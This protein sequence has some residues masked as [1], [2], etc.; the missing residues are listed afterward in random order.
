ML[1]MFKDILSLLEAEDKKTLKVYVLLSLIAPVID[2]VSVSAIIPILN[3]MAAGDVSGKM[4]ATII[5]I[6]CLILVKGVF[7]LFR[8]LVANKFTNYSANRLALKVFAGHNGE[9]LLKHNDRNAAQMITAVRSDSTACVTMIVN[10]IS[11]IVEGITWGCLC[12]IL[13]YSAGFIGLI[14]SIVLFVFMLVMYIANRVKMRKYG[15]KKRNLEIRMNAVITTAYG[16]YKEL[17]INTKSKNMLKRYADVSTE[18]AVMQRHYAFYAAL[19]DVAMK[20]SLQAAIY[21]IL[22]IAICLKVDFTIYIVQIITFVTIL[23]KLIPET[24]LI[25]NNLNTI[26]YN[27]K[28][29]RMLSENIE[30]FRKI[31]AEEEE[32]R[33]RR[34]HKVTINKGLKVE[35][36][37]FGYTNSRN[38]FEDASVE[39]PA[40][41]TIAIVGNSGIGKTSFLDLILGLLRPQDG[42]IYYDDYDIVDEC[43]SEGKC[44]GDLGEIVSYIPQVVFMNGDTVK[45]NVLFMTD[46][47]EADDERIIEC[48]KC[49]QVW[50][51]VASMPQGMDTILGTDG[52]CIS[53]GQ[54]QRIALARA[55][56][57]DF[58]L[59]VMDE[60]TAALDTDTEKAVIDSIRE[61]RGNKTLIMVTHHMSLAEECEIIYK[62][63]NKKIVR[64]R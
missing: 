40:G 49:A 19:I 16:A 63:E 29:Y 44:F 11:I 37:T 5:G 39:L 48:L 52:T 35:H 36:L 55:L 34:Q 28:A 25:V 64:V 4:L 45:N 22:A 1:K 43:D 61:L 62:I 21:F 56:Y 26:K 15:E 17:K 20:N 3:R 46:P 12:L 33:T 14:A 9:E 30:T 57:R 41:H 47:E 18:F 27:E 2:L 23:L 51:D 6:G 24:G 38:I 13:I 54:R 58:D 42:H 59:L 60:A 32:K 50:D 7:D 31:T 8:N 53:G 10:A